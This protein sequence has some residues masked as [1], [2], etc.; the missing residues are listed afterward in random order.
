MRND[1]NREHLRRERM[2]HETERMLRRYREE[3]GPCITR[4]ATE[5]ELAAAKKRTAHKTR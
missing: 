2:R 5:E 1:V 4:Q 3:C